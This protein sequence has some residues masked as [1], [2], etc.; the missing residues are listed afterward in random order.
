MVW[1][2][3]GSP[4]RLSAS[5]RPRRRLPLAEQ[6][7][8]Q[9]GGTP[10]APSLAP[11]PRS[12]HRPSVPREPRWGPPGPPRFSTTR[13]RAGGRNC[14]GSGPNGGSQPSRPGRAPAPVSWP[15]GGPRRSFQGADGLPRSARGRRSFAKRR[16]GGRGARGQRSRGGCER[17]APVARNRRDGKRKALGIYNQNVG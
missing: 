5:K 15:S 3:R 8:L 9:H 16:G 13:T 10:E 6:V 12:P 7:S 2:Q 11:A 17:E 4:R 14:P 1:A